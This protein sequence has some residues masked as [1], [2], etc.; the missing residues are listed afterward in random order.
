MINN[1]NYGIAFQDPKLKKGPIYA[2]MSIL[3]IGGSIIYTKP[4]PKV[5]LQ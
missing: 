3:K 1:Y 5:Y 4:I 2:A